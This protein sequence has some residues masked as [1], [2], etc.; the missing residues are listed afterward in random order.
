[1]SISRN[2]FEGLWRASANEGV[3]YS[4]D[5]PEAMLVLPEWIDG[6][7][8]AGEA[9][10]VDIQFDLTDPRKCILVVCDNGIGLVNETRMWEW[11][12][13]DI[14]N[15]TNENIYG[16]G[17]KK[18]LTKFCP[19]YK[20][21]T[22][23]L[24]WRRKD[25]RQC[26]TS[27][28][29]RSSPYIGLNT[30]HDEDPDNDDIC[31]DRGTRWE[32]VFDISVL[33]KLADP[34]ELVQALQEIIRIRYERSYYYRTFHRDFTISIQIKK[35]DSCFLEENSS[36]WKSLKECLEDE[37]ERNNVRKVCDGFIT[38]DQTTA[39]Y[40]LFEISADG[41]KF[42]I[43]GMPKFGKKNMNASRVH[44]ARGGRYIEAMPYSKFMNIEQ[45]PSNNGRIGF[46][47][48]TGTDLPIPCTTKVKMQ[49]ECP[50][51]KKMTEAIKIKFD[52]RLPI[53]APTPS[54]NA[55]ASA[56]TTANATANTTANTT[57]NASAN[58]S[59]STTVD[60]E[61]PKKKSIQPAIKL[62]IQEQPPQSSEQNKLVITEE[63]IETLN[64]LKEKYGSALLIQLLTK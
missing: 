37:V 59:A 31:P 17:S 34:H 42:T 40:C 2:D 12:S 4:D 21:A 48:F 62:V 61:S 20:T 33:G 8:G 28:Y 16:H 63:D 64:M 60:I 36:E 22:W 50:I 18:V 38:I 45:H 23:R 58:A 39:H 52:V 9:T 13:T 51:F 11:A 53:V 55:N 27:L 32:V 14:G 56:N 24:S 49:E 1:M 6:A 30:K 35:G 26:S 43:K 19:D 10:H 29:T 3:P 7:L 57:A 44:I 46:V 15:D 41:R 47:S 54:A 25:K 5:Y